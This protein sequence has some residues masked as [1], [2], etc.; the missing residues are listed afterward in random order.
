M[1]YNGRRPFILT[2]S[3]HRYGLHVCREISFSPLCPWQRSYTS[4]GF[5]SRPNTGHKKNNKPGDPL[6]PPYLGRLRLV[7]PSLPL[8]ITASGQYVS[9][10]LFRSLF[11]AISDPPT[12]S[13]LHPCCSS[14]LTSHLLAAVIHVDT[15][16]PNSRIR[17]PSGPFTVFRIHLSKS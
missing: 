4:I 12:S 7:L 10:Q 15:S 16:S 11:Y 6:T 1:R 5:T 14:D 3:K 9:L 8:L 17:P 2:A 13:Q